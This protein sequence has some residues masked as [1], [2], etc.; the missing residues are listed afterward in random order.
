MINKK[1]TILMI[2]HHQGSDDF[3]YT[4]SWISNI[5]DLFQTN[6]LLEKLTTEIRHIQR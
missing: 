4:V 5:H 2:L 3:L 1:T 6:A